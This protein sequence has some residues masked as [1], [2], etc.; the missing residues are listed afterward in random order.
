MIHRSENGEEYRRPFLNRLTE[1]L[2]NIP[3]E[4]G[5]SYRYGINR[6]VL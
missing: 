3:S 6:L 5:V 1:E 4:K 2:I